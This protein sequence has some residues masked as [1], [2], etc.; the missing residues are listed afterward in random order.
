MKPKEIRKI[1]WAKY[2]I[3]FYL[4][5][6]LGLKRFNKFF[7]KNR[8][9]LYKKID[10]YLP[11]SLIGRKVEVEELASN[12]SKEEFMYSCY[13]TSRPKVFRGAAKDWDAIKNWNLDFFSEKYGNEEIILTDNIGLANQEFEIL[14][15]KDY[16][17]Q[18]KAGTLKYLKF[19]DLVKND[20]NL[21]NDFDLAW[22]RNFTIPYSWGEDPKMFMGA[23]S[24]LTPVHV[25][26]SYFLFI[27]V[28]GQKKWIIY[29]PEHRIYLDAR[30]DR[31]FYF[32]S[33]ANPNN[34]SDDNFPLLKYAERYEIILE[35]GDVLWIPSFAWH[36]V[37]NLSDTIGIR[38]GTTNVFSAWKSSK[39]LTN[40]LFFA[41]KPNIFTHLYTS[42]FK[43]STYIF[44]KS[45]KHQ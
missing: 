43:K 40:L 30:T 18:L 41:T 8:K 6:F 11:D 29:P 31:T 34:L 42:I 38:F 9:E 3:Y 10:S 13:N 35:P 36:Q 12:I 28:M 20:K 1:D 14:T 15:L 16:I 2:N 17:K 39:Q 26:F 27:Q 25:G 7:G 44:N 5:H 23:K 21:K 4:E 45:H 19:S 33:D 24:T 37:E 32:Y 22:L